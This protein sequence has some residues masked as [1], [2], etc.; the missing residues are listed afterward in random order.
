MVW[1]NCVVI[2]SI[3]L[4]AAV[5]IGAR[6]QRGRDERLLEVY[7]A[8]AARMRSHAAGGEKIFG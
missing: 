4:L 5:V 1:L 3:L 6:R 2:P 8:V 7:P